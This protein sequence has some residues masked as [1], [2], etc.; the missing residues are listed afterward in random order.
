MDQISE[1]LNS[2]WSERL[3]SDPDI[4]ASVKNRSNLPIMN[5]KDEIM[6]NIHE[7]PVV[8]IRGNTGKSLS[9]GLIFA[10]TNPQYA[11]RLFIELHVQYIKIPSSNIS[12]TQIVSDI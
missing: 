5:F 12:C 7:S 2:N 3:K 1:D 10:S 4:Q 8:L 6:S 11:D 9:E